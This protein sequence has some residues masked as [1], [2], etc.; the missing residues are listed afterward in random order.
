MLPKQRQAQINAIQWLD[1]DHAR[2]VLT[3]GWSMYDTVIERKSFGKALLEKLDKGTYEAP[4]NFVVIHQDPDDPTKIL[5]IETILD[6]KER[7]EESWEH[8]FDLD[9]ALKELEQYTSPPPPLSAVD[10]QLVRI[11]DGDTIEV[12]NENGERET[13][14]LVGID[15]PDL[16]TGKAG[17][18]PEM[19]AEEAKA[20]LSELLG[21]EGSVLQIEREN[22]PLSPTGYKTDDY[23]R[24][25]AVVYQNGINVNRQMVREK[26]AELSFLPHEQFFG[27][28]DL[29]QWDRLDP[30]PET[31]RTYEAELA[32]SEG[33]LMDEAIDNRWTIRGDPEEMPGELWIGDCRFRVPPLAIQVQQSNLSQRIAP[34][35]TKGSL[36]SQPGHTLIRIRVDLYFNGLDDINGHEIKQEVWEESDGGKRVIDLPHP[37]YIDGLR[38]LI[39]QFQSFPFLPVHNR[40]LNE[41][42]GIDAVALSNLVV[43]TVPGFPGVLQA[44]LEMTRFDLSAYVYEEDDLAAMIHWP[45]FRWHI[46]QKLMPPQYKERRNATTLHAV[47]K[48]GLSNDFLFGFVPGELAGEHGLLEWEGDGEIADQLSEIRKAQSIMQGILGVE[49]NKW[50]PRNASQKRYANAMVIMQALEE[51][52]QWLQTAD[53]RSSFYYLEDQYFYPNFPVS[54]GSRKTV[55]RFVLPLYDIEELGYSEEIR[56]AFQRIPNNYFGRTFHKDKYLYLVDPQ[57]VVSLYKLKANWIAYRNYLEREATLTEADLKVVVYP[58]PDLHL[59]SL[60]FNLNNVLTN[61]QMDGHEV[62]TQQFIGALDTFVRMSFETA[63]EEAVRRLQNLVSYSRA[64]ARASKSGVMAGF[65][66]FRN[67]L[68]RIFGMDSI[69]IEDINITTVSGHPGV[70]HIELLAF[71]FRRTQRNIEEFHKLSGRAEQLEEIRTPGNLSWPKI[72]EGM[73]ELEAYPDLE[74]PTFEELRYFF[75]RA[76]VRLKLPERRGKYVDPDF[77]MKKTHRLTEA[78]REVLENPVAMELAGIK[79]APGDLINEDIETGD[80]NLKK[81]DDKPRQIEEFRG[82]IVH[83]IPHQIYSTPTGYSIFGGR[84]GSGRIWDKYSI[85]KEKISEELIERLEGNQG[86][87]WHKLPIALYMQ[88]GEILA[89]ESAYEEEEE[90]E[91]EYVGPQPDPAD[92]A[93][94][95]G[96]FDNTFLYDKRGRLVRAFPGFG[97]FLVDEGEQQGIYRIFDT[98]YGIGSVLSIDITESKENAIS[99]AVITFTDMYRRMHALR[100]SYVTDPLYV[101]SEVEAPWWPINPDPSEEML[102]ARERGRTAFEVFPGTRVHLRLGYGSDISSYPIKFNGTIAE[103]QTGEITTIVCQSDGAELVNFPQA[104]TKKSG[105]KE[106]RE[107]IMDLLIS[108][109]SWLRRKI[110]GMSGGRYMALPNNGIVHFGRPVIADEDIKRALGIVGTTTAVGTALG[111]VW[112]L[113]AGLATGIAVEAALTGIDSIADRLRDL[114]LEKPWREG[115]LGDNIYRGNGL[116]VFR[117]IPEKAY[118]ARWWGQFLLSPIG[119]LREISDLKVDINTQGMTIWDILQT[120]AMCTPDYV[121][122]VHPFE[123]RSTL[124]FGKPYFGLAYEYDPDY[125]PL[126]PEADER[127][128][129]VHR[130]KHLRRRPFCQFYYIDSRSDIIRNEIRATKDGVFTTVNAIYSRPSGQGVVTVHADTDIRPQDQRSITVQAP[131]EA[132]VGLIGR[133]FKIL[134]ADRIWGNQVPNNFAAAVLADYMRQMYQGQIMILGTPSM[135][136]GDLV[137]I[138]DTDAE[139]FGPIQIRSVTTTFSV[140][141]GMVTTIV[142]DACVSIDDP[143]LPSLAVWGSTVAVGAGVIT[144]FWGLHRAGVTYRFIEWV[145]SRFPEEIATE[146]LGWIKNTQLAQKLPELKARAGS[147]ADELVAWAKS[148]W[149]SA[150]QRSRLAQGVTSVGIAAQ[151]VATSIGSSAVAKSLLS[152]VG[153]AAGG[154]LLSDAIVVLGQDVL[155]NWARTLQN[156][157]AV[158]MVLLTWRG[159]EFSAGI[160]GH[161]GLVYGDAGGVWDQWIER[162]SFGRITY[163]S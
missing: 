135:K 140:E 38:P 56:E 41:V 120:Y 118:G 36:Q 85:P 2:V 6:E 49:L 7:Y 77:F 86:Q 78:L 89:A 39:A 163:G 160:R 143:Y 10:V 114:R 73:R 65:V 113:A 60:E 90:E 115:E 111:G 51:Y 34:L 94:R 66:G 80:P 88:D 106:A 97:F 42:M 158:T 9:A 99:L 15:A 8:D 47:P 33:P 44:T 102:D 129:E 108:Q 28:H 100:G 139:M 58:I 157:Q 20:R 121:V 130:T 107:G 53:T 40:F 22:D 21:P 57:D 72:V 161:Q 150:N 132:S 45:L 76:G 5:F 4:D 156:R 127:E 155:A 96:H 105:P 93:F 153:K 112:G 141:T 17:L 50:T 23:G 131:I 101:E 59:V 52:E 14:R 117:K 152:L 133:A 48:S 136:P 79:V 32:W 26:M 124:F 18:P 95:N 109:D 104:T 138:N 64:M 98:L 55:P 103:I 116:A 43:R 3:I 126:G 123:L 159:K 67:D 31:K 71:D 142:P 91:I 147:L 24:T 122:A 25:L 154:W 119:T 46:Q 145:I 35:R 148:V 92:E 63:S 68:A 83:I 70:Y 137:H 149:A 13:V 29:S 81:P 146:V 82:E 27:E 125:K 54:L 1:P 162:L 75:D 110:R 151:K 37:Y 144:S 84:V 62:P 128:R 87:P 69:L 19:G 16:N 12:A 61:V 11:I 74:L 134:G 30:L